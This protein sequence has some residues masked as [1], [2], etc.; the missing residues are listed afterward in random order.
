MCDDASAYTCAAVFVGGLIITNSAVFRAES[1]RREYAPA[2]RRDAYTYGT[3]LGNRA[4]GQRQI[5]IRINTTTKRWNGAASHKAFR[6]DRPGQG[7]ATRRI[8]ASTAWPC[9][10]LVLSVRNG[11]IRDIERSESSMSDDA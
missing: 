7:N 5:G 2:L 9:I 1:A 4:T 10:A 8:D 6:N 3:T 11:Q